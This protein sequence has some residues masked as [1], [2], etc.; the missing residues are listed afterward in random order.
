LIDTKHYDV[1]IVGSGPAGIFSA[2][3][4]TKLAPGI[5]IL[6]VEKGKL[7][8]KRICPSRINGDLCY[9]CIPC[10][11][12]SG[13]G[14]A[15]AFSDGKLTFSPEVGGRLNE[16][17]TSEEFK[18][19]ADYVDNVYLDFG[20]PNEVF[21][22]D[23]DKIDDISRR[24]AKAGLR[25]IPAR[26]R[27]LGTEICKEVLARFYSYLSSKID[28]LNETQVESLIVDNGQVKGVI[29]S[30]G[31]IYGDYV[32]VAPGRD[33]ADW[34]I[35]ELRRLGL[36]IIRN[37]VDVGVRVEIPAVI[38]EEL[39]DVL[40]EPKLEF[41]S[42]SFD[43][44]VRTF[45]MN[46]YGEVITEHSDGVITVNGHSYR[47]K[48]TENTNFAILISTTFTEPFKEPIA[49]AKYIAR[50]ANL[51]GGGVIV[52]RLGDLLSG[53]RSTEERIRKGI[54]RPTLQ[55][56]TPGDLSF[57]LPYRH[58]TG[59]LEMLKALD[60]LTPGVYSR[61]TLLY[62]VEVKFYSVRPKLNNRLETQIKNLFAIGDGAGV[63]RGLVQASM[64]GVISAREI[65]KRIGVDVN[66][67][68]SG[69]RVT[70]GR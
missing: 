29:T 63:T 41:Y 65:A 42:K 33:G 54:V 46:P 47:D 45:C 52:Q 56:A 5:R 48:K 14:G 20:A 18:E 28:I 44:R 70:L 21:G 57:V 9:H 30:A 23:E 16:Y 10:S 40:Y 27:H 3:E 7:L 68:N 50:L 35:G 61:Y 22:V 1:I 55:S 26:V 59:I 69:N 66:G 60:E 13:W 19:I 51:L 36:D 2:Y 31:E 62:G 25:L 58:L 32:I 4:L 39:T 8:E 12:M 17:I 34:L 37:P 49:Y 67:S 43:D 15:G 64:S 11:I 24:S 38:M 6:L 53:R